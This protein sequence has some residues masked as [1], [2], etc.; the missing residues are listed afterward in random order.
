MKLVA[1]VT[2]VA[3]LSA[4]GPPPPGK[5]TTPGDSNV[6]SISAG[7]AGE[8]ETAYLIDTKIHRCWFFTTYAGGVAPLDCCALTVID[9]ARPYLTWLPA[10][11]CN[12]PAPA[13]P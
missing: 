5:V 12:A 13:Q 4:C 9:E 11:A 6:V 8:R 7:I 3:L 1:I 2:L 10:N